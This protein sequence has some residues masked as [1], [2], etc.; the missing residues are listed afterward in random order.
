MKCPNCGIDKE[1]VAR[2]L[3]SLEE[4]L[5]VILS[6]LTDKQAITILELMAKNEMKKQGLVR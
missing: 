5:R 2:D 1:V 4:K 6:T 3:N